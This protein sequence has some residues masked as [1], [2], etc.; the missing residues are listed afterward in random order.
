MRGELRGWNVHTEQA[1]RITMLSFQFRRL[2]WSYL[3]HSLLD[4]GVQ[5]TSKW[6]EGMREQP[7]NVR[8]LPRG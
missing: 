1:M 8:L 4:K 7:L 3:R 5:F 6:N 2:R